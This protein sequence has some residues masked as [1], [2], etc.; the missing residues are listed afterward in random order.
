MKQYD[1]FIQI[2][3]I[4][5]IKIIKIKVKRGRTDGQKGGDV[6]KRA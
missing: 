3:I 6:R 5:I 2:I 1:L 4:I